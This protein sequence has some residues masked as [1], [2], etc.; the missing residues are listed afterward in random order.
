MII[1]KGSQLLKKQQV[2][3]I[4]SFL[5]VR[6][7]GTVLLNVSRS[8]AEGCRDLSVHLG[9]ESPPS[10]SLPCLLRV[11]SSSPCS[12]WTSLLTVSLHNTVSG[13]PKGKEKGNEGYRSGTED[14]AALT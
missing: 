2:F 7:W 9:L 4:L 8:D 14:I 5:W 3:I 11:T 1:R 6:E 13:F 12:L 10:G